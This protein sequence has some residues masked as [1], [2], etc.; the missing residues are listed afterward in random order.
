MDPIRALLSKSLS[1]DK[2][3]YQKDRWQVRILEVSK[4]FLKN[5]RMKIQSNEPHSSFAFAECLS[6][7]YK[8]FWTFQ[9][10]CFH[11]RILK[12]PYMFVIP[13]NVKVKTIGPNSGSAFRESLRGLRSRITFSS[14]SDFDQIDLPFKTN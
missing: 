4:Q 9:K 14:F 6:L 3:R 12:V 10:G 13:K 11:V 2:T 1:G 8:R 7:G 5:N